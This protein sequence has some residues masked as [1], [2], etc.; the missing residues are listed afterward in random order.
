MVYIGTSDVTF[1]YFS[2]LLHGNLLRLSPGNA[3]AEAEKL[4]EE[5]RGRCSEL[6]FVEGDYIR[7]YPK[8]CHDKTN[9]HDNAIGLTFRHNK[10]EVDNYAE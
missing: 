7:Q 10:L 3:K 5:N 6:F 8:F 1:D 4:L 9:G 2:K